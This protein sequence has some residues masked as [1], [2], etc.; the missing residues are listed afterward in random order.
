M[1]S[2]P[3]C[4]AH[5]ALHCTL[6]HEGHDMQDAC[7]AHDAPRLA[8]GRHGRPQLRP[9]AQKAGRENVRRAT[10]IFDAMVSGEG[11]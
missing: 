6:G 4:A 7:L 2:P 3:G 1:S 8:L 11:V 5:C 9:T 10:P